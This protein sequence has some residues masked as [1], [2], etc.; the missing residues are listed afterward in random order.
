MLLPVFQG[1]Q[2][3]ALRMLQRVGEGGDR[4]LP[5]RL[6]ECAQ[7][8][9]VDFYIFSVGFRHIII[10]KMVG[11]AGDAG[12]DLGFQNKRIHNHTSTFLFALIISQGLK[13]ENS[14]ENHKGFWTEG[15][16]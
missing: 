11:D 6:M 5:G 16:G 10:Q 12:G 13:K 7:E 14:L 4:Q 2:N 1:A 9:E 8:I 15:G 3:V